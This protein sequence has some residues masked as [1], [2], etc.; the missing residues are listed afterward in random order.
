MMMVKFRIK[1]G[2]EIRGPGEGIYSRIRYYGHWDREAS[3]YYNN[4][5]E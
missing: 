5:G 2:L 4:L 3:L 1:I